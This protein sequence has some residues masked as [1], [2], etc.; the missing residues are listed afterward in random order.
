MKRTYRNRKNKSRKNLKRKTRRYRKNK[1]GG[2]E[3]EDLPHYHL[4]IKS[5]RGSTHEMYE[6]FV[7]SHLDRN[8]DAGTI[9]DLQNFVIDRGLN[10]D[11]T[12]TPQPFTLFWKGK[13]L[14][15]SNVK[16]R[17]I[18]VEGK[19]LPVY[20]PNVG[21]PIVVLLNKDIGEPVNFEAHDIDW[22]D[23]DTPRAP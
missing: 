5:A 12:G 23:P 1:L 15:D 4:L 13:K 19:K 20:K 9:Q 10:T 16:L 17:K 6:R 7:N 3:D 11:T 14:E 21:E 2:H 22:R 8:I 18:V